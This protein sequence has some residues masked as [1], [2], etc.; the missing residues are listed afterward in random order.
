MNQAQIFFRI[1]DGKFEIIPSEQ[2]LLM[3]TYKIHVHKSITVNG[4]YGNDLTV[5]FI[6][7]LN[8][9]NEAG[10]EPKDSKLRV[11]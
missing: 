6:E 5:I 3:G 7:V 2:P 4:T 8:E 10:E 9:N 11:N 1:T